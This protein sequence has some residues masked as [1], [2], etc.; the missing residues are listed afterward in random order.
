MATDPSN[1]ATVRRKASVG[2][3]APAADR[4]TSVGMTL[5]SVVIS[6]AYAQPGRWP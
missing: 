4:L 3:A 1:E 6:A 2:S 5:A